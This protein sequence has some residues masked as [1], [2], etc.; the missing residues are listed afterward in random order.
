MLIL[1]TTRTLLVTAIMLLAGISPVFSHHTGLEREQQ[2]TVQNGQACRV[3]VGEMS[4]TSSAGG[5]IHAA[6]RKQA[7][8]H[9]RPIRRRPV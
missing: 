8:H 3:D 2:A 5:T 9:P 6:D 1:L 7:G 4:Q